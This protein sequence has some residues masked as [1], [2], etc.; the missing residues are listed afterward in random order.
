MTNQTN[1]NTKTN[2][3]PAI[4]ALSFHST[5][6]SCGFPSE[7]WPHNDM[8]LTESAVGQ[9]HPIASSVAWCG[10]RKWGFEGRHWWVLERE[11]EEARFGGDER[12]KEI[13]EEWDGKLGRE[14][15]SK[16]F[17]TG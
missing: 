8:N 15:E 13:G 1:Q 5:K 12:F 2:Q 16:K 9:A 6:K 11:E 7:H 10:Q 17:M 4:V 14:A 3:V